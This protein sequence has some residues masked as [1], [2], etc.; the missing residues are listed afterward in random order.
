[1]QFIAIGS[2]FKIVMNNATNKCFDIGTANGSL[3]VINDCNGGSSQ[4]WTPTYDTA[5]SSFTIKN[6]ASD[7]CLDIPNG[8][9]SNGTHPQ[10]YDCAAGNNNQKFLIWAAQ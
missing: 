4:T 3:L 7:R 10:L 2:N 1:M 5:S 9:L 6:L 8:S